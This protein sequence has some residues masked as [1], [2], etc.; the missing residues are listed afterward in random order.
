MRSSTIR[1]N[2][3]ERNAI[4]GKTKIV[5]F[6]AP[7]FVHSI[8]LVNHNCMLQLFRFVSNVDDV[9][10]VIAVVDVVIV[11]V[12]VAIAVEDAVIAVVNVVIAVVNV[13][14]AVVDVVTDGEI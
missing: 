11:V 5:G 9:V 6:S 10:F 12:D 8:V 7:L 3:P 2:L 1:E 4:F 13:V 14:I